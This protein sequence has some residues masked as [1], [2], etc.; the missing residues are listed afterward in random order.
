V[1]ILNKKGTEKARTANMGFS[2][3]LAEEHILIDISLI[4]CSQ[5][6]TLTISFI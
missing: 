1:T 2:A 3:T 6:L 4:G 5:G